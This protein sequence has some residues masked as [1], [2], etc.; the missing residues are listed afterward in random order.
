MSTAKNPDNGMRGRIENERRRSQRTPPG[1]QSVGMLRHQPDG[2]LFVEVVDA[3]MDGASFVTEQSFE[4]EAVLHLLLRDEETGD[5][6]GHAARVVW[7]RED[8]SVPG[9]HRVG[10]RFT[11]EEDAACTEVDSGRATLSDLDFLTRTS[12]LSSIPGQ[13]LCPLLNCLRSRRLE[14]GE[15]LIVQGEDGDRL[16]LVEEGEC[17]VRVESEGELFQVAKIRPGEVV[18]EMAVITG[19]P[20]TAHVEAL[21]PLKVWELTSDDFERVAAQHPDIR[22]FLT[23][24]ITNRFE[25]SPHTADRKVGKFTI[26]QPLGKGGWSIVYRGVHTRLGMPVAIKMMRHDMAMETDF[27]T[28]F[29]TEAELIA[30][31]NH[32]N[33]VQVY[34]IDEL[35]RTVFIVMEH[36]EGNS[37]DTLLEHSGM[38]PA[39]RVVHILAQICDGLAYAHARGIVHRDIKPA[40]IFVLDEDRIKILDFGLACA[41]GTE[42]MSM[43][44]TVKYAPPEQIEGDPVDGRSD[45]YSLGIMAYEMITGSRPYP[46]DDVMRL[47]DLHCDEDIPDP[48]GLVPDIPPG[49][50]SFILKACRRDPGER[51]QSAAEAR[52]ALESVSRNLGLEVE[53]AE[54]SERHMTSVFVFYNNAQKQDLARLLDEF[55]TRAHDMGIGVK[56]ADFKDVL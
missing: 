25:T 18:G 28:T 22:I 14:A 7:R 31:M 42:D 32:P 30:P 49:L 35:Y 45:I 53:R 56:V 8:R 36:L 37:L 12:L 21:T 11:A 16:F 2:N 10:L 23:E 9:L 38:L 40:N 47:M 20:R 1:K 24:L 48:A 34:D 17:A 15:R 33:I 13:S 6:A 46:E 39:S 29:R 19:E 44:G 55:G 52:E 26:K 43:A 27:I 54:A 41:I 51:Y 4:V 50:R 5:W 3:G